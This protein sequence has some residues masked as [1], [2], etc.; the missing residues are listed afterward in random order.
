MHGGV[1]ISDQ[2]LTSTNFF[3]ELSNFLKKEMRLKMHFPAFLL[4][5]WEN[6]LAENLIL[7]KCLFLKKND[8]N[9]FF[10]EIL[11][12]ADPIQH[13]INISGFLS[14]MSVMPLPSI[15]GF[16][17]F[18]AKLQVHLRHEIDFQK[19]IYAMP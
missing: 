5:Y 18:T 12:E 15:G 10:V 2:R 6:F 3:G 17:F 9:L 14:F 13:P 4:C 8:S 11:S 1:T 7:K 16:Q 19:L